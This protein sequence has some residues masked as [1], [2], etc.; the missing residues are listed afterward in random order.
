MCPPTYFDVTYSINP[1]MDP[2]K[3]VNRELAQ[4]QWEGLRDLYRDL[5]HTVAV[6]DATPDL[7]DMVFAANGATVINGAV[8]LARFR[9]PER[10]QEVVAYRDWFSRHDYKHVQDGSWANEGQGDFLLAGQRLLA[11]TGFRTARRSHREA[12]T[13]FGR[14]VVTL[15]LIDPRFYHLDTALAVLDGTDVMYYPDAFSPSSQQR[16]QELFPDAILATAADADCFGLNAISDGR[17][18]VLPEAA[19]HLSAR[20][21]ERGFQPIGVDMSELL[22]A[23][24][25]VKCCT[26]ELHGLNPHAPRRARKQQ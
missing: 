9:H 5:G 12:R 22:K 21:A 20:L 13:V 17:H 16:L 2:T 25:A 19:T 26:L 3:P 11:G 18:V 8:L 1:W 23:G 14:P 15:Q 24:G 4:L 7:P 10:A 6:I